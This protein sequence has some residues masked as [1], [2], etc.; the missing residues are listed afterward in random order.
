MQELCLVCS[1]ICTTQKQEEE[2]HFNIKKLLDDLGGARQVANQLGICRTIPY[3]WIKRSFISSNYLSEIK[4][5]NP[6]LDVNHYFE[7]EEKN[8]R[9]SFKRST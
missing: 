3:G 4:E 9:E 2:M 6:E 1:N 5:A 7:Q 8:V